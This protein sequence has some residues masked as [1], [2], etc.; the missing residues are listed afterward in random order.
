MKLVLA[1]ERTDVVST[2][3][4]HSYDHHHY[5]CHRRHSNET[6]TNLTK[7]DNERTTTMVHDVRYCYDS[8]NFASCGRTCLTRMSIED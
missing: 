7:T 8:G 4:A 2:C 3:Y 6:I 5:H 1:V